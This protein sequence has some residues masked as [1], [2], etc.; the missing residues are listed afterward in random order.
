MVYRPPI[1][2]GGFTTD[3]GK[4]TSFYY[5]LSEKGHCNN[6]G[7][8]EFIKKALSALNE[9]KKNVCNSVDWLNKASPVEFARKRE[10]VISGLCATSVCCNC[11]H[12]FRSLTGEC[13]MKIE[14]DWDEKF[15]L[16]CRLVNEAA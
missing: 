12:K 1:F 14:L 9:A 16:V 4:N 6:S 5:P 3:I 8:I 11:P 13:S 2:I 10:K 15:T 7:E